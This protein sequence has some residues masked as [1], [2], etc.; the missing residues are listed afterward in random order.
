MVEATA[1]VAVNAWFIGSAWTFAAGVLFG[2]V[3]FGVAAYAVVKYIEYSDKQKHHT[4]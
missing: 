3:L 1:A 4:Q 2:F